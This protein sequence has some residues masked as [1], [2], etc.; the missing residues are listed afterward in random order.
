MRRGAR[1]LRHNNRHDSTAGSDAIYTTTANSSNV[2]IWI[3]GTLKTSVAVTRTEGAVQRFSILALSGAG[4]YTKA[5]DAYE[6]LVYN[7][8]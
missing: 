2:D 1:R 7:G 8:C 4:G 3:N 5:S 6:F